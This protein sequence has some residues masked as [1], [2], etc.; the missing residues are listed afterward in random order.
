M[1]A[2]KSLRERVSELTA[3][4]KLSSKTVDMHRIQTRLS[5]WIIMACSIIGG[6]IALQT[7]RLDVSKNVDESVVKAF[8]IIMLHNGEEYQQAR[9]HVRSYVLARR[10]CDARIISRDLTDDDFVRMIEFYDLAHACVEA[11]LCEREVTHTFFGRHANFDWPILETVTARL[12]ANSL[13]LKED[14]AF[15]K[16]YAAFATNPLTSQ[17]CDGNF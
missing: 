12:R 9:N 6:A 4:L 14:D 17:P 1:S 7:Y 2:T 13:S 10:E 8:D 3:A 5:T 16:G 15:A 11:G